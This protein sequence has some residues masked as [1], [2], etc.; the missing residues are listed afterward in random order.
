M[1]ERCL[2]IAYDRNTSAAIRDL[3]QRLSNTVWR[4]RQ[5]PAQASSGAV[6]KS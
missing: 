1:I 4:D 6:R 2:Q 5:R 3:R